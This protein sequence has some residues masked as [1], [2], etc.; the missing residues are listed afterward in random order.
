MTSYSV[1]S[2]QIIISFLIPR[3]NYSEPEAVESPLG[4]VLKPSGEVLTILIPNL[5]AE[6]LLSPK[7]LRAKY[8]Q[9]SELNCFAPV[10][11]LFENNPRYLTVQTWGPCHQS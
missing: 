6:F 8:F 2:N 11:N 4:P 9:K 7:P 5:L 3:K 1:R 10:Q